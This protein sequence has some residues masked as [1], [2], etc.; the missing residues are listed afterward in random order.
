VRECQAFRPQI[1]RQLNHQQYSASVLRAWLRKH[2][3]RRGWSHCG[4]LRT[5]N[6]L[7]DRRILEFCLAVPAEFKI[8]DGYSRFLIR[9]AMEGVLPRKIQWRTDKKAFSPD[10]YLRYNAQLAKAREF[11]AQIRPNDPVR[12]LVDV[13]RLAKLITPH[14]SHA[15]NQVARDLVPGSI[16]LICFLRQFAE[17]RT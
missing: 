8:R 3:N 2:A 16:Y 9:G 12:S 13:E 7:V 15:D 14:R 17:F 1:S 5:S 10:Y 6:P 11:V 4:R